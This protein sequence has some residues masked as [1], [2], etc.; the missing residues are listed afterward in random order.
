MKKTALVLAFIGFGGLLLASGKIESKEDNIFITIDSNGSVNSKDRS[1]YM[2]RLITPD[3]LKSGIY[4]GFGLSISSLVAD[5]SPS[6]LT[7]KNNNNNKM[8]A[9]SIVTGYNFNKYIA[10]EARGL[11]S[12]G[13]DDGVDFKNL[14]I[15]LKPQYEVYKDFTLYSLIGV[16]KISANSIND[17]NLKLGKTNVQLGLGANYKL[18]DNFKLFADYTYLGKDSNG[19]LNGKPTLFKASAITTGVTY[20]F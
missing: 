10:A 20:D 8:V 13:Y 7:E 11:I 3:E 17:N 14:G 4:T 5:T 15:Y 1:L 12:V 6:I 19:K 16:G 2:P 9:L 18:R